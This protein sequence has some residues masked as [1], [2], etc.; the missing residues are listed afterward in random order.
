M[1]LLSVDWDSYEKHKALI[2]GE[3]YPDIVNGLKPALTGKVEMYRVKLSAP[4][5]T[6]EKHVTSMLIV[7]LKAP[8]NRD[9]V[10]EI[11]T[12]ISEGSDNAL[13]FRQTHEDENKYILIGGWQTIEVCR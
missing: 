4:T 6:L 2:D 9:A 13:I 10:V 1:L 7:T 8:A 12:K 3:T 5:T 11:L